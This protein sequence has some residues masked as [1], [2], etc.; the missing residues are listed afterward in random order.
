MRW[1]Q[2]TFP[3]ID[4]LGAGWLPSVDV[5]ETD[6]EVC[7]LAD[8][9]GMKPSDLDIEVTDD[10]VTIKGKREFSTKE[11]REDYT[12]LERNYGS[13]QRSFRLGFKPDPTK[14]TAKY[15][16]GVLEVTVPRN[17]ATA[18]TH[19]VKISS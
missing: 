18:A 4:D 7:L 3:D 9:P 15:S 13:F 14:I 10:V 17:G 19:H 6:N 1:M 5:K 11:V 8:V 12:R 2:E 16:D